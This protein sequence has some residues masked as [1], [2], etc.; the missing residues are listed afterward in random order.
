MPFAFAPRFTSLLACCFAGLCFLLSAQFSYA[1]TNTTWN[2][3]GDGVSWNDS[4]NWTAGVPDTPGFFNAFIDGG[5]S[6]NSAVETSV[7]QV[8]VIDSLSVD[9]G[10]LLTIVDNNDFT[11]ATDAGRPLSGA[12]TNNGLIE[13]TNAGNLTELI[14]RDDVSLSGTGILRL[15]GSTTNSRIIDKSGANGHLTSSSTI[16]GFGQLGVSSLQFTNL[17]GA[18]VDANNA[19]GAALTLDP[20]SSGVTNQATLR[21]SGGGL[22]VLTGGNFDNTG[23]V[24]EALDM[25]TVTLRGNADFTSGALQTSG[26]G[27]IQV[28]VSNTVTLND[29]TILGDFRQLDNTNVFINGTIDNQTDDFTITN[30]GNATDLIVATSATLAGAG[31]I[32]LDGSS[33]NSR[34]LDNSGTDGVLTNVNNTLQGRGQIGVNSLEIINQA[35]GLIDANSLGNTLT[36]DPSNGGVTNEGTFH[37][38]SGGLLVLTGGDYNNTGGVIDALDMST[39]SL[40]GGANITGGTLQTSGT[41]IVRVAVSNPVTLNDLTIL[42]DF[43]QL[44]NSDLFINGTIDNQSDNFTI[45]NVGN[46]TDLTVATSATLSGGGTITLDG[47]SNSSRIL[48]NS[49]ADGVLTNANN[50]LQG[51]GQIGVNSLEIIN[52]ASGLIDANS[53]GNKLTID[54]N[55]G[56][57]TNQGILRASSGGI[58]ELESG[59]FANSNTIEA[60]GADSEVQINNNATVTGGTVRGTGGG[61]VRVDT[62]ANVF[63][64]DVTF[65]GAVEANNNSDFGISGTITNSGT[66]TLT[67]LGSNTDLE[68]QT[69]GATLAGNG[70]VIL[71]TT[72]SNAAGINGTTGAVLTHSVTHTIEGQGAIGENTIGIINQGLINANVPGQSLTIGPHSGAGLLNT[73]TLRASDGGI[74]VLTGNGNG[75]FTNTGAVI[76]ATGTGSEVQLAT[77]TNVKGGTVRAV[78]D[79]LV[80][81]NTSANV[82][83]TDV[84]FEGAVEANNNSDFGIS[85]TITNSGT[86]TLTSSGSNTDLEVQTGGA[87]LAGNGKVIL[88]TT[89]SNAAGINGTTGAVLTHSVTHT[90]EGQGAIGENTIGIVNQGLIDANVTGQSLTIDPGALHIVN[91]GTVQASGGGLLVLSGNGAGEFRGSGVYQALAGSEIV[92]DGS[93]VIR[94]TT[95]DSA[96]D[97]LVRSDTSQNLE[98]HNVSNLGSFE[99]RNNSDL[100]IHGTIENSGNIDIISVGNATDLELGAN[101]TLTGGG[102]VTLLG[103]TTHI[104]SVANGA[105]LTNADNLIEGSGAIDAFVVN[106]GRLIG[107]SAAS[108]F[109]INDRLSGDGEIENVRIDGIHAPGRD[110][111]IDTA[112]VS[113]SGEYTIANSGELHIEF[114]G[115]TIGEFDQLDST[116]TINLDGDLLVTFSDIDNGYVPSAG[117]EF[118]IIQSTSALNGAFDSILLA[119]SGGGRSIEWAPVDFSDPNK[120]VLQIASTNFF[121]AD[122][123]EDGDVDPDDLAVWNSGYGTF[124]A[125]HTDGDGDGSLRT[126]GGDFLVWQ[127]QLGLGTTVSAAVP[128]PT[129]LS[130]LLAVAAILCPGRRHR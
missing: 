63:F 50:T 125:S 88:T 4:A 119:E 109:E 126:D 40:Q 64:T 13:L 34:I 94:N 31:T 59:D 99:L 18:L 103:S 49:G 61:L 10:D 8:T 92:L 28:A 74:M 16:E 39:V 122:Y 123:D 81:V 112:S 68:V 65:E 101:A 42:G 78:S 97:G 77:N 48:D 75:D 32:T 66:I 110:G 117:D 111:I 27:I 86:I 9:A 41:G 60:V 128:E 127:Q 29:L 14:L 124:P 24:I 51:R 62:S 7:S 37:A 23:G 76:E 43:R 83:F 44:D 2:G 36:V 30:A 115:T 3:N 91:T 84:T 107:T 20:S 73:G 80:R 106:N 129:T 12:I 35:S 100:R 89:S 98:W 54:P 118:T 21:A 130:L 67:S 5:N 25:S 87:T 69:G 104:N 56:G 71:T 53:I 46:A 114:G 93:A 38:S 11:I 70:K 121:A 90:I 96:G 15:G 47:S 102:T 105:K 6:S 95:F 45:T 52:Q 116:G 113:V 55:S 22:L 1:Q 33:H 108:F 57:V 72:S 19:G 85:G 26:T 58:L 82:F 120:I 79:G 17:A